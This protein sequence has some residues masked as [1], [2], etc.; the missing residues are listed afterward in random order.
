MGKNPVLPDD[1]DLFVESGKRFSAKEPDSQDANLIEH[2]QWDAHHHL[3]ND[4]RGWRQNGGNDEIE[5]Y[6]I[7]FCVC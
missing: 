4:I 7:F 6:G 3:I 1:S 5:Q 2:Q